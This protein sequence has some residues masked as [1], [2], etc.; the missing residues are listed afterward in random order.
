[1][2]IIFPCHLSPPP[3]SF[4]PI[5]PPSSSL[6]LKLPSPSPFVLLFTPLIL[7]I[8]CDH[9][10]PITSNQCHLP[11]S[12]SIYQPQ[13]PNCLLTLAL[14]QTL[15]EAVPYLPGLL[16]LRSTFL[17]LWKTFSVH[18]TTNCVRWT[19]SQARVVLAFVQHTTTCASWTC[20]SI[21]HHS[22]NCHHCLAHYH[23]CK[24][25]FCLFFFPP[26]QDSNLRAL[27]PQPSTPPTVQA[28]QR[29]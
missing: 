15:V 10:T 25:A 13:L 23:M 11:L 16:R 9:M 14:S 2:K 24:L 5:S 8:P 21:V 6:S 12:A 17:R 19:P 4:C 29:W 7:L 3:C 22:T 26:N 1:M 18:H 27:A 20:C 28:G